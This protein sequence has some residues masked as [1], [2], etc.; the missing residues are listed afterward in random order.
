MNNRAWSKTQAYY[1]PDAGEKSFTNKKQLYTLGLVL[2][3]EFLYLFDF[4]D[5]HHFRVFTKKITSQKD[6]SGPFPKLLCKKGK[7]P[8]QYPW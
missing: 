4:G 1:S 8:V 5:S 6:I 2:Q 3:K 7:S